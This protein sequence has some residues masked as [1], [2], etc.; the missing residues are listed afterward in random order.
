MAVVDLPHRLKEIRD[1]TSEAIN[2]SIDSISAFREEERERLFEYRA[3]KEE[4]IK[5]LDEAIKAADKAEADYRRS[6]A[7]LL[8][9]SRSGDE[10]REK[11]AYENAARLMRVRGAFE[12]REKLLARQRD[13]IAREERRIEKL[14]VRSE[15]MGNRFRIALNLLNMSFDDVDELT[16]A[17]GDNPLLA[18][19]MLAERESMSLSRDLHDGPVQK[20]AGVGLMLDISKEYLDRRDLDRLGDELSRTR[21]HLADALE[22]MRSF[23]FQLNPSGLREGL[24]V[25]LGRLVNEIKSFSGCDVRFRI[26]GGADVLSLQKRTAVYKIIQQAVINAVRGG[27]AAK[28]RITVN[29]SLGFLSV[30]I[31]D[32]GKGFDVTE[33]NAKAE[34]RGA[35]GLVNMRE[36]ARM[37]GGELKVESSPGRGTTVTLE[38]PI[39]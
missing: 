37:I 12:E 29:L 31:V 19:M 16:G 8:T 18:S 4:I 2:Y 20:F 28:V 5:E 35:W 13:D 14:L 38:V 23:L 9:A 21:L 7:V 1:K 11:E 36:R 15:E 6:R 32:D 27:Q 10:R 22:E 24:F 26:E 30:K 3:R 34:E 17:G 25:P 39:D 33:A